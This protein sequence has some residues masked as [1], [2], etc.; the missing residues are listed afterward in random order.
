[1]KF[2]FFFRRCEFR[3]LKCLECIIGKYTSSTSIFILKKKKYLPGG[4]SNPGLPRDRRGYLPLYYRGQA[5]S[6]RLTADIF[7][8]NNNKTF[9]KLLIDYVNERR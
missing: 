6:L 5:A 7:T 8:D 1:M 9:M 2:C 4:E 3:K